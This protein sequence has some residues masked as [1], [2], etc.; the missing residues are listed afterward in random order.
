LLGLVFTELVEMVEERFSTE[1]ADAMLAAAPA[2]H[3]GAYTAVGYYSHEELVALVVKLSQLTGV[4][5][6]ELVRA[7]GTHLLGRFTQLYPAIFARHARFFDFVAAIDG[8]IHVEVRMLYP[9]A[10][11]PRFEVLQC[12]AKRM[13]L[14]YRSPR[15]MESLAL[16]LLDGLAAHYRQ[17]CSI[18]SQPWSDGTQEGTVFE[19]VLQK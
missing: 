10:M 4:V 14:L 7:F 1:T 5:I 18:E 13:R 11:L 12:D 3:G 19:L 16:G 15:R 2:S 17:R 8:E 9:H 6:P